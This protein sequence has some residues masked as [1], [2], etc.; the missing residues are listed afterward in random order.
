[1]KKLLIAIMVVTSLPVIADPICKIKPILKR[2][3]DGCHNT[4]RI[5]PFS[6]YT[7]VENVSSLEQCISAGKAELGKTVGTWTQT[8]IKYKYEDAT[9]KFSAQIKLK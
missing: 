2:L 8:K 1:M 9:S 6:K 7:R 5:A 3:C 4:Y